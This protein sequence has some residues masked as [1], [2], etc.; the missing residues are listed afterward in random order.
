MKDLPDD[1]KGVI[2]ANYKMIVEDYAKDT[3]RQLG[4]KPQ[5]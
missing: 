1:Y 5:A 4:A 2:P 3:R